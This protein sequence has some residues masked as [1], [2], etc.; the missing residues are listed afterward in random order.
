MSELITVL[1]TKGNLRQFV[2]CLSDF[3]HNECGFITPRLRF[4]FYVVGTAAALYHNVVSETPVVEI[5][6]NNIVLARKAVSLL[7]GTA[8]TFKFKDII[9]VIGQPTM[10]MALA[11]A[12]DIVSDG[13]SSLDELIASLVTLIRADNNANTVGKN[14][15][16]LERAYYLRNIKI[17]EAATNR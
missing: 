17:S 12:T 2:E 7:E 6:F 11:H 13:Y 3:L 8:T 9:V 10:A 5:V 15:E 16:L 1:N 14:L 4:G